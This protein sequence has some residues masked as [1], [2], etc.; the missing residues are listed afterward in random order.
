MKSRLE[1][2]ARKAALTNRGM[3]NFR[4]IRKIERKLRALEEKE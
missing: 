4:M 1:L 3:Q 2:E